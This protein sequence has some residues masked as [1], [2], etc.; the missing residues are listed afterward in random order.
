MSDDPNFFNFNKLIITELKNYFLIYADYYNQVNIQLSVLKKYNFVFSNALLCKNIKNY[1]KH[2][3]D[4]FCVYNLLEC[5][6][7]HDVYYQSILF[8]KHIKI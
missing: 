1:V 5:N 6:V 4:T 3:N 2:I 7:E 8:I